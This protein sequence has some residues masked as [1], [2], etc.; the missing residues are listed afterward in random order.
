MGERAAV[1]KGDI[2][3]VTIGTTKVL[4]A[5]R[6]E[7]SGATRKTIEASEFGDDFDV[8]EFGT[9]DGGTISLTEVLM[10]PTDSTG[11]ALLDSALLNASKFGSGGLCFYVNSTSYMTVQSGGNILITSGPGKVSVDRNGLARTAWEGKVSGGAMV[12][13]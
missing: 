11:Q 4:G 3:K 1:L 13:V 9:A 10:D 12:L 5:G 7:L 6:Y 2:M 8:F